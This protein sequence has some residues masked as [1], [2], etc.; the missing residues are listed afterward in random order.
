MTERVT[1]Q[2]GR[3]CIAAILGLLLALRHAVPQ[4]INVSV[5]PNQS[6]DFELFD[7][8]GYRNFT[9]R[10][11][12]CP[13]SVTLCF[14]SAAPRTI[15]CAPRLFV[16]SNGFRMDLADW[17]VTGSTTNDCFSHGVPWSQCF[18]KVE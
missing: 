12:G 13:V 6:N 8:Y 2:A 18:Y 4:S 3:L 9:S 10:S 15:L 7:R 1:G 17:K 16:V 14:T 5:R 11:N